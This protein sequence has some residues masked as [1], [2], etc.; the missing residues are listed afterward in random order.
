MD[1]AIIWILALCVMM[2]IIAIVF[3]YVNRKHKASFDSKESAA[4]L[5]AH[6]ELAEVEK[7][8]R[9]EGGKDSA[10]EK[11]APRKEMILSEEIVEEKAKK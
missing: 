3:W 7:A 10:K 8:K 11:I 4:L 1:V 5:A 2:V 6:A 9:K